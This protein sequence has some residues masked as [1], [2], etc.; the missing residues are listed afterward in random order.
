MLSEILTNSLAISKDP[1]STLDLQK[2]KA[3]N[4]SNNLVAI[5][6]ALAEPSE[7]DQEDQ[8]TDT[9]DL[10]T[11]VIPNMF[12]ANCSNTCHP[13][14]MSIDTGLEPCQVPAKICSTSPKTN[15]QEISMDSTKCS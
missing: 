4:L 11:I 7:E 12:S 8:E 3:L 6:V 10:L 9:P 1:P 13:Q 2:K 15:W 14:K 5:A